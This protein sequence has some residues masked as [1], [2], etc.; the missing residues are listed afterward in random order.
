MS[1]SFPTHFLTA[2]YATPRNSNIFLLFLGVAP[3]KLH[4]LTI[5][6]A[7]VTKKYPGKVFF[8]PVEGYKHV[9][10]ISRATAESD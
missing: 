5:I 9:R 7:G 1:K 10:Y 2:S 4:L 8:L 3:S 6:L